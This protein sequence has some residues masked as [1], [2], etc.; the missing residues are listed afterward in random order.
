MT[1]EK[2]GWG[3]DAGSREDEGGWGSWAEVEDGERL[4]GVGDRLNRERERG[5]GGGK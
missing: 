1:R 4:K 5:G 3:L 2:V